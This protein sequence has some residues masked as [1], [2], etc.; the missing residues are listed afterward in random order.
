MKK[1]KV[2]L[3]EPNK[4]PQ[5]IEIENTLVAMQKVVDGDI[6][7]RMPFDDEVAIVYNDTGK[8]N[9]MPPNRVLYSD[10]EEIV[11]IIFG[12]FFVCYAPIESENY[13]SLPD[14]LMKSYEERFKN[15]EQIFMQDNKIVAVPFKPEF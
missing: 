15:P 7:E 12:Q 10:K 5:I 14:D 13:M 3:V 4:Y 8:F 2:L 1:I 9:G 6:E 11:D